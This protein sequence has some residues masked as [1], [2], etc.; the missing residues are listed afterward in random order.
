MSQQKWTESRKV[1]ERSRRYHRQDVERLEKEITALRA[2]RQLYQA[3]AARRLRWW[4]ELLCTNKT[5]RLPWLI[6]EDT[7]FLQSVTQF[8][9]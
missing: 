6:E 1:L 5:P 2:E 4:I 7:K 9:W 3:H 8:T